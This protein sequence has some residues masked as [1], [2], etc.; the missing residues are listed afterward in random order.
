MSIA[1]C[2]TCKEFSV[3]WD[4]IGKALM[5]QHLKSEHGYINK[6]YSKVIPIIPMSHLNDEEFLAWDMERLYQGDY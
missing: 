5:E 4:E 2:N 1:T 6:N 3:P